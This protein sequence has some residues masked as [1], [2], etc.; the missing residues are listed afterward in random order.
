MCVRWGAGGDKGAPERS[1]PPVPQCPWAWVTVSE[2]LGN[3]VA[4]RTR[5]QSLHLCW[6]SGQPPGLRLRAPPPLA[7]PRPQE[8]GRVTTAHHRRGGNKGSET[9]SDSPKVT[10]QVG[11]A[12]GPTQCPVHLS[13]AWPRP[14]PWQNLMEAPT[15]AAAGYYHTAAGGG[16]KVHPSPCPPGPGREVGWF[17]PSH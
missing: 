10:R 14:G 16:V 9:A 12:Q 1:L 5:S 8:A 7:L 6:A 15:R 17:L 11:W 13:T 2:D 3:R 4:A